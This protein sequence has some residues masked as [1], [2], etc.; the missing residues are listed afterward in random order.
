MRRGHVGSL[1]AATAL[2][3]LAVSGTGGAHAADDGD[4]LLPVTHEHRN[5]VEGV[6][7]DG[8]PDSTGLRNTTG[9][10]CTTGPSSAAN[11]DTNCEGTSPSNETAIAV[12][13]TNPLNVIGS[14]NDYQLTLSPGGY[15]LETLYSRAHVSFDGGTSWAE[16]GIQYPNYATTG[17][18]AVAFDADGRAY[19]A[20]LGFSW[21]QN[22]FCCTNPDILVTS[23]A[24]GGKSWAKPV[25]VGSGSGTFGSQGILNDKEEI[26]AWGHG[27]ALVTWTRYSDGIG[28]SYITSPIVASVTHDGGRTWSA[29]VVIS[30]SAAFCT[31]A[32]GGTACD[33]DQGSVVVVGADSRIR[34]SFFNFSDRT[35]GR[36]QV[37]V[38]EVDPS[39]GARLAGPFRVGAVYDGY[40]DYPFNIDSRQTLQDSQFR[41][42]AFGPLAADPTSAQH[43]A[44]VWTDMRNSTLPTAGDPYEATTNSDVIVSQS[45]DGGVTWSAPTAL[46]AP[47]DQFQPWAVYDS[48][49]RLRIGYFDRSYDAANHRFGYTLATETRDGSLAFAVRQLTTALSDPTQG[50]RWFSGRTPDPAYPNPSTFIGDYSA[51]AA[52][53]A[54]GVVALWTDMRDTVCFTTRCGAGEQ[55]YFAAAS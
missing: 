31:G 39:S 33:S 36:D 23:S 11:V 13:P 48:N 6:N 21:S 24:D 40:T 2:A 37:L 42:W 45:F 17:D 1:I 52:T 30:G 44:M 43:L 5:P 47:G 55:A 10:I 18:P 12:N 14:A 22:R 53:P 7:L 3:V 8:S 19:L 4:A 34:V 25:R 20:T 29:P 27:N 26:A 32:Q 46:R 28:G 50:D 9:L 16:Y 49:G 15:Y 54:G 41:T 51:V 35:T 38:V